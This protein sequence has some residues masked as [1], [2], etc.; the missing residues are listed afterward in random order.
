ML[1]AVVA[2]PFDGYVTSTDGT[3]FTSALFI[4]TLSNQTPEYAP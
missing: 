3:A 4:T 1:F 2:D